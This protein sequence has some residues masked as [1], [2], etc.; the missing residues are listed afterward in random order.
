MKREYLSP[1][2]ELIEL[3]PE[4]IIAASG[5]QPT[6]HSPFDEEQEW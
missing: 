6:F 3:K 2:C 4:G 5:P 1:S